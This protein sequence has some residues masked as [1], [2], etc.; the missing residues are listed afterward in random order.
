M[1]CHNACLHSHHNISS[2]MVLP[3]FIRKMSTRINNSDNRRNWLP[4]EVRKIQDTRR[5]LL[6]ALSKRF[7]SLLRIK[8]GDLVKVQL[9]SDFDLGNRL[10]IAKV[11]VVEDEDT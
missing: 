11:N 9:D 4:F 8:K 1:A 6:L 7:T 5:C 10:I 3:R 2:L